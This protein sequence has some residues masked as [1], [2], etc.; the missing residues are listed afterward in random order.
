MDV[1][2]E[3]ADAFRFDYRQVAPIDGV[4]SLFA[5]NLMQPSSRLL[6]VLTPNL[7]PDARFVI[8]D[9][10]RDG[11]YN[12]LFRSR[13]CLSP[14]EVGQALEDRWRQVRSLSEEFHAPVPQAITRL[15]ARARAQSM[16]RDFIRWWR[17]GETKVMRE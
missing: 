5:F 4:C 15:A 17:R 13:R 16:A 8:S 1:R 7:A 6:D 3:T 11:L 14:R 12:R 9:G 10:N 2:F